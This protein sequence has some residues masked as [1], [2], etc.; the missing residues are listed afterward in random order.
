V[1][2]IVVACAIVIAVFALASVAQAAPS[3]E[4]DV[5]PILK[6]HCFQ[7]HGEEAEH[8]GGLDLRLRRLMVKGGDSG[9]AIVPGSPDE[10][11]LLE[12]LADGEMPPGDDEEKKLT[13]E[14]IAVIHDW[15][16]AGAPTLR[17]EPETIPDGLL[18]TEEDRQ[19]WS[20]QPVHRPSIPQVK[21]VDQTLTPVDRF[22]LARL[23]AAGHTFAPEADKQTLLRRAY[24]DL[25]GL[26]PSPEEVARFVADDAPDAYER[27]IDRLL[28]SPHYGQ[29]W[30]RHWLDV[31][32]YADSEGF[33]ID[34]PPRPHAFR[35]RDYVIRSLNGD[36]PLD[37]FI[38]EQLAG[39]ELLAPPYENLARDQ[40]EKLIATGFLRMA[41]DGTGGN[42]DDPLA[43]R[44]QVIADSLEIVS[45][46]LLGLTVGCARCHDHRYDPISQ[47]DYYRF[48]A[49]FEPAYNLRG[50]RTPRQRQVSLFTDE[51]RAEVDRLEAE[52]K[53][54]D[55]LYQQEL[56]KAVERVNQRLLA[57]VPEEDRGAVIAAQKTPVRNR[58]KEQRQILIKYPKLNFQPQMVRVYDRPGFAELEKIAEQAK[59]IRA[60]KPVEGF[61]RALT[62]VPG[63][64]PATLV[65]ARGDYQQPKQR[66]E[67]GELTILSDSP[68]DERAIPDDDPALP[69]TG[70]RLAYANDLTRSDHPL[71]ARV[72]VNRVW[73][74]HF[75]RGLVDT[76]ADF[77]ALGSPPSHPELLDWLA[78]ELTAGGWSLKRLH[79]LIMTSAA[80]RQSGVRSIELVEFDPD[81]RLL[82]GMNV[83]RLEA[84]IVRDSVLAVSGL[85]NTK[86]GGEPV[87]VMPDPVGQFVIGIENANA[88]IQNAAIPM[89]GEEH[90]RSVYVQARR[91]RPLTVLE[92]F[93]LPAMEPNC[94]QRTA[95][96]VAPQSLLL[97]NSEFVVDHSLRFAERIIAEVGHDPQAQALRAFQLAYCRSGDADELVDA[98]AFLEDRLAWYRAHPPVKIVSAEETTASGQSLLGV[99][100][101]VPLDPE[102]AALSVLCQMLLSSNE[103]LYVD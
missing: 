74:H 93:D 26:P 76:P 22:L 59:A 29:R 27:L 19:F 103:F 77:G 98:A 33:T 53:K 83:R 86:A 55:E 52:A 1:A 51:D 102:A 94:Q 80:Y 57:D 44:D 72:L 34:D 23:E 82:G 24:F 41:P 73:M 35:Y 42:V 60:R 6:A 40:A 30:G 100:K 81:N 45:T 10:S 84:E 91:S 71:L 48:R 68:E 15:I 31:A 36:K 61:A 64:V 28:A 49:I 97:L 25:L 67:P 17:A 46:T 90:R 8:K 18:V 87:P 20:F 63:N 50:W 54:I 13:A 101:E 75:G 70:R 92:T 16:A 85:L 62:E 11:Y 47:Q 65:F 37:Q 14:Q 96:T 56:D 9:A 2:P 58:T 12:R 7:C 38:R 78:S 69:T 32:G 43:A 79:R 95:S 5:R 4:R 21:H 39:D 89:H 3:F 99:G 88:G 66:V